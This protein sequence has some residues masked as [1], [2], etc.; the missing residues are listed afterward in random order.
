MY[1]KVLFFVSWVF[2]IFKKNFIFF[3]FI[4]KIK[5]KKLKSLKFFKI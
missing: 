4:Q 2:S 3:K 1:A 5:K